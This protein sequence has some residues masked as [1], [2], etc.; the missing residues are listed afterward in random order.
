[1]NTA[2]IARGAP[3]RPTGFRPAIPLLLLAGALA[4]RLPA[5]LVVYGFGPTSAPTTSPT[6]LDPNLAASA[7]AGLAGGA[8]TGTGTPLFTAGS[9][10]AFFTASGWNGPAPGP[11]YFEFTLTPVTG[12]EFETTAVSFGYRAT[13][14]G[15]TAFAV[16]ASIDAF[17]SDLASGT[18]L[19][20]VTWRSA[21]ALPVTLG[22]LGSATTFRIYASGA[23]SGLGT[24]RVDDVTVAGS[25]SAVPEPGAWGAL[26][27]GAALA[28]AAIRRRT[29]SG[30]GGA[31]K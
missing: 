30:C 14:S 18:L 1:M 27:G 19:A 15:P 28:V 2:C 22:A 5:Q 17:S 20:D 25:M 29:R 24:L 10:G 13:S 23:S 11:N 21:G 4:V 12:F 8:S 16:R 9:G 31:E 26:A 3:P 7:F 6:F